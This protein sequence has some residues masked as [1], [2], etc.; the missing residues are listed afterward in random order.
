[1]RKPDDLRRHMVPVFLVSLLVMPGA[2]AEQGALYDRQASLA[3]T[4]RATRERTRAWQAAQEEARRAVKVEGWQQLKLGAGETLDPAGPLNPALRWTKCRTDE[5]G[6]P[7]L[8]SKPAADFIAVTITASKP[9]ALTLELSRQEKYG[10]FAYR[11]PPSGAGV[12][13][14]D[15]LVWVNG[16][17]VPLRNR[18]AGYERVPVGKRRG[19][20]EALLVDLPLSA[21]ENRL[22]VALA[23]GAQKAWFNLVRLD[24]SPVP[25]LWAMIEH[26]FPRERNPLLEQVDFGWFDP[27]AGW[28]AQGAE[29]A[30]EKRFLDESIGALGDEGNAL[31]QRCEKRGEDG[32]WLGLCAAAAELRAALRDLDGLAAAVEELRAAFA[33]EYPGERWLARAAAL[34]RQLLAAAEA[35]GEAVLLEIETLQSEALVRGNPLLAGKRLL[36]VK[37]PTY[38]SDHYYDEFIQG[39]KRFGGALSVLSLESG[40]VRDLA[41]Q[42]GD[43]LFDRYDL[44]FDAKRVVFN[45]KPPKPGGFRVYEIGVDGSGLRQVTQ[46]PPDEE[47]R[48]ATYSA[49]PR[50]ELARDPCRYGHWSDDMHPCYLPDGGIAF[51]STRVEQGVLCG[52]HSLTVANLHRIHPDGS[53]LQRLSQGALSE[54]CPT[55]MNDG[56]ILYNRWEYVDKGAGAVQSLWA[57]APDGSR[58]QEVYGNNITTPAVFNQARHVPGRDDL[59]VC[60]GAGHCPGNIGAIILVDMHKEK[61]TGDAMQVLTPGSLPK[62]NWALRQFRNGRWITD[63]YGPWYCDPFPLTTPESESVAGKFFLVSC[64]PDGEWNDPAGYGL[65][66]LDVFGNRVLIHRDPAISCWQARPLEARAAPPVLPLESREVALGGESEAGEATVLL[67][68]VY[69]GLDGV[70]PGTVKYLRVM[71][72]VPRPWAVNN[73]YQANDRAPGQ[74]VAISLYGHLSIKVLHGI[75]PVCEDGSACLT[76]PAGRNLFFQALDENF[77]E[78]QRMRTFVNFQPGERRSC[79][80]CHEPR[81][82]APENRMP[83]ALQSPPVRL[84]PQPGEVAPRPVHYPSDIQPILDRHCVSCHG[85]GK[86]EGDLVLTGEMTELFSKSYESLVHKDLLGYI[87]EFVGPKPEGADAMGYAP[88]VPPYTYGSHKSKL[89]SVLREGHHDVELSREEWIKLVTWVD[90]NGPFYGSYFGRRNVAYRDRPDFRPE[91]VLDSALGRP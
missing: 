4:M 61:R 89:I 81:N 8:G 23:K 20:H 83:L 48:I 42:L 65:Y 72:Q 46:P 13:E 90:A 21:G 56:R 71:E 88:A 64:N 91:P 58:S 45:Y 19:L 53:G 15:A 73:G 43:G 37:R 27:A 44:S 6:H 12:K 52:G 49:W 82:R 11:P 35:P 7:S 66:L 63:I 31:C 32:D 38:D 1:M 3:E 62:G 10:G 75:V 84:Q 39:I 68:D 24:P 86:T 29:P 67:T 2:S 74:M 9:V 25:A 28:F 55:V 50:E 16:R 54:F 30:L 59:L 60:L 57:M 36:F 70:T 76:V 78:I 87:Q 26:D 5:A 18:L 80:G 34:R 69:Q 51:T 79:I 33:G 14:A 85:S 41:P 47:A 40:E 77:M 17:P 22:E